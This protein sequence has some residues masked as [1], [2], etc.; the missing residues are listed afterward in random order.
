MCETVYRWSSM[1]GGAVAGCHDFDCRLKQSP[2]MCSHEL[3]LG[4]EKAGEVGAVVYSMKQVGVQ[5]QKA[6]A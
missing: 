6:Q 1:P 2:L 3:V 5:E 4:L